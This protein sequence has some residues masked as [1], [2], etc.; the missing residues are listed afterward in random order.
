MVFASFEQKTGDRLCN[1]QSQMFKPMA[2]PMEKEFIR[3][4]KRKMGKRKR[5]RA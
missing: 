4:R 3:M 1:T 2:L 5:E